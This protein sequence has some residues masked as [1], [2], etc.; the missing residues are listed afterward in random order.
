MGPLLTLLITG[1]IILRK[2]PS[3]V[4]EYERVA[5][6]STGLRWEIGSVE[7]RKSNQIRFKNVRLFRA[8]SVK[9]FFAASEVDLVYVNSGV[10]IA[11]NGDKIDR[12]RF[13]PGVVNSQADIK[14][15]NDKLTNNNSTGFFGS[16][17]RFFGIRGNG[18][19]FWHLS[20]AKSLVDLD[21]GG[22]SGISGEEELRECFL[23]LVSRLEFLSCE[24][25]LIMFDE[26]EVVATSLKRFKLRFVSGN[27]YQTESA[28]RSEWSFLIPIVSETEREHVSI[29]RRRNSRNL[30]VTLKTGN[31]PLP[32]ELV[33][34]FCSPFRFF[35]QFPS[36]VCGEITAEVERLG[37]GDAEW[38]YSLRNVFFNDVDLS[39]I[40]AD[41]LPYNLRGNIKGL[42]VNEAYLGN[43]KLLANGWVEVIDGVI[44]RG[45]FHRIVRQFALTVNPASLLDSPRSEYPFTRCIFNYK[46][47]HDGL[48]LWVER[49][50]ENMDNIFMFNVGDGVQTL[51]M[52]VSFPE[53]G[54]KLVSYH[55]ALSI[56]ATDSAP[57]ILLTPFSKHFVPLIPIDE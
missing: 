37:V 44:D 17:N 15:S 46:L 52:A 11:A 32:C 53:G 8:N 25:V 3:N 35:G 19:G 26:V 1:V 47:Q 14:K 56:F 54:S 49:S 34:I 18:N 23:E 29:V 9:P 40:T 38:E 22:G 20:V 51:P 50:P 28:I 55:N 31:M 5:M 42:R 2:L 6:L 36:R 21:V 4:I 30:S 24:P 39:Q 12:N 43:G 7:Y 48:V 57:I 45:L 16:I 41:K 10:S 33:A 27:L 13:F